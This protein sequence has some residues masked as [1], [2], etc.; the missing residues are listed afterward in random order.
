MIWKYDGGM[1]MGFEGNIS[2]GI[3]NNYVVMIMQ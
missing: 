2:G 3:C 1:F